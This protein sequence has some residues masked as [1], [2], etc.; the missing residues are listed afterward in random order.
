MKQWFNKATS[1]IKSN[2][3]KSVEY[4]GTTLAILILYIAVIFGTLTIVNRV[5]D[6]RVANKSFKIEL[7]QAIHDSKTEV[8]VPNYDVVFHE[9]IRLL[10]KIEYDLNVIN[11]RLIPKAT[12]DTV[13]KVIEIRP[14]STP[15]VT[16]KA[17]N[18]DTMVVALQSRILHLQDSLNTYRGIAEDRIAENNQLTL[19]VSKQ[20]NRKRI[21]QGVGVAE[22]VF[23][24]LR[25]ARVF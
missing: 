9:V 5:Y 25:S 17:V 8:T 1:W 21:F 19:E 7:I 13:Y 14:V 16:P 24:G 18:N 15:T 10:D 11:S 3:C 22:A 2:W 12:V 4:A 20:K 23:I 6:R